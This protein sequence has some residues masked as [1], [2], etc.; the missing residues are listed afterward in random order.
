MLVSKGFL[1]GLAQHEADIFH[2]VMIVDF[3]IAFRLDLDIEQPV[4][5]KDL[6]HVV[7]KRH[8]G[9]NFGLTLAVEIQDD[10]DLRLLRFRSVFP[11]VP[12]FLLSLESRFHCPRMVVQA[13]EPRELSNLRQ[14]AQRLFFSLNDRG[15]LEKVVS[16]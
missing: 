15:P 11:S 12:W 2:G 10:T 16:S 1:E 9:F 7:E 6:E 8:A 5:R 14:G 13:F 4:A 3:K